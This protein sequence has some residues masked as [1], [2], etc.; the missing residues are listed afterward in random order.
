MADNTEYIKNLTEALNA[1]ADWLE[2]TEIPKLKD[3]LRAYQTGFASLY[4]LYLKK[5]LVLEDPYKQEV[6][7]GELQV[8]DT[9]AFNEAKR[10]DQMSLR[11]SN[12][13]T[14]MDFLVNFYQF[15]ADFLSLDRLKRIVG[16][17][18]YIDWVNLT[19]DSASPNTKAAAELTTQIKQGTDQLTMSIISESLSNLTK[20]FSPIMSNIKALVD[21]R[22]ELYKLEL[23]ESVI[24]K[25][26]G[27]EAKQ[28][29]AIRKKYSQI[30][31]DS[32]F[33]PEL[34]D[35]ALKEDNSNDGPALREKV[36]ASLRVAENKPKAAKPQVS[37]KSILLEGIY[38]LGSTAASFSDVASKVDDNRI[39]LENRKQNIWE[40]IK[41]IMH[42]MLNKEP[43]A[44]IYEMEYT[45]PVKGVPVREKINITSFES[46]LARKIKLLTTMSS[47]GPGMA[48]LESMQDEQIISFL[49]KNIRDIQ[50][51]HKT[52]T[53]LDEFFKAEADKED[54]DRIRGIKP[55]LGTIKNA[56]IRANSKRHEYTAQKEETE[57]LKKLGVNPD[58]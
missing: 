50:A 2:K 55:E 10:L 27:N 48:K 54:R 17:V 37:I 14:Q 28:V 25:M 40:K 12:Y 42:Q 35:E 20:Q 11:L 7:I 33:Y 16:L 4:N 24:N 15:S 36:L 49:E 21:Y 51:Y 45:D 41:K 18:K 8:P 13:D 31:P 39:I 26:S 19:P 30:F 52:L 23:R 22:K 58:S 38:S 56:I 34:V 43:E 32:H 6:K 57:Q 5:R 53:A 44:V 29:P 47:R 3:S 46:D 9:G 1:R